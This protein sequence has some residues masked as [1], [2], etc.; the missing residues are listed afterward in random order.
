MDHNGTTP[1]DTDS[2]RT[3]VKVAREV[4][5]NPSTLCVAGNKAKD[6]LQESRMI[7][8]DE[9]G[10]RQTE[11]IFTSG[12]TESNV[13]TLRGFVDRAR[14]QKTPCVLITTPIEHASVDNTA[15]SIAA[16]GITVEYVNVNKYGVVNLG[17]LFSLIDKAPPKSHIIVSVIWVNNEIGTIQDVSGITRVCRQAIKKNCR[18]HIHLDATQVVG[19]FLVDFSKMDVDSA[20]FSAHKFYSAHGVGGLYLRRQCELVTPMSVSTQEKGV[21][22]GTENVAG[23]S[24][25][26][27]ALRKANSRLREGFSEKIRHMRDYILDGLVSRIP[28]ILINSHPQHCAYNTISACLPC[29]SRSLVTYLSNKHRICIAVGSACSKG[30]QSKTLKAIGVNPE[31]IKGSIR[32]SLGY[33]NEMWQCKR[34]LEE[35]VRYVSE[36]DQNDEA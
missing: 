35:I 2:L 25:M 16:T 23:V 29:D 11:I 27:V 17:H 22:A 26:A 33:G 28:D 1:F 6:K 14:R 18:V 32:I 15:K 5:G 31:D 12:A 30:G 8:A 10:A 13:I 9:V 21:R 20:A 7:I 4:F 24:A 19:R 36:Y 3:Y 34:V